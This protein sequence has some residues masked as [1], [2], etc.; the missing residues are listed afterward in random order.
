LNANQTIDNYWIRAL[1]NSGNR[2]LSST[3]EGGVNSAILRYSGAPIQEPTSTQQT[4]VVPL[5]ESRLHPLISSPAP[6]RPTPDGG[7]VDFV[8]NFGFDV[9]SFLFNING[10]SFQPPSVPVLLQILSGTQPPQN[11]LPE[12]SVYTVE[13]NK[14]VQLNLPSGLI[15]GPHPFHLHGVRI[16]G[17]GV[18]IAQYV[19][20]STSSG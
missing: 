2:N 17:A 18:I 11:L 1:P 12:G 10:T 20:S 8:F 19:L 3:F 6:G 9:D 5:V 4:H 7:D 13:R 15:G 16:S 14:T